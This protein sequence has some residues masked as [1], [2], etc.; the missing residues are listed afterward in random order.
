LTQIPVCGS[1]LKNYAAPSLTLAYGSSAKVCVEDI[2]LSDMQKSTLLSRKMPTIQIGGETAKSF[3][4]TVEPSLPETGVKYLTAG[5][6]VAPAKGTKRKPENTSID[7]MSLEERLSFLNTTTEIEKGLPKSDTLAQL[8][9]QG[10]QSKDLDILNSVLD[11]DDERLIENSV[12]ILPVECVLPLLS[13]LHH[14]LQSKGSGSLASIRWTKYVLQHHASFL[15]SSN[16]VQKDMLLPM[17][18]MIS[19]RT[20]NYLPV[21]RIKGKI[22]MI[23]GQMERNRTASNIDVDR[24]PLLVYQD[25]SDDENSTINNLL[26]TPQEVDEDSDYLE[27]SHGE[28]EESDTDED[29]DDEDI[30]AV[31]TNGDLNGH[32]DDVSDMEQ[33]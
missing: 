12:R 17:S 10:L 8:L 26:G 7:T 29:E 33:D 32:D 24:A 23:R 25:D 28:D 27:F 2:N 21:L 3:S 1:L 20:A 31:A 18:D 14:R 13:N 19:A 16:N 15:I 30:Q 6:P 9:V 22:D 11:R 4:K 5:N